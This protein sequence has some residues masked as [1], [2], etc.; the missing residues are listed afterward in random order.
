MAAPKENIAR[1]ILR[2]KCAKIG[3]IEE[4]EVLV[5]LLESFLR[6]SRGFYSISAPQ[7]NVMKEVAIVRLPHFSID[8]INPVVVRRSHDKMLSCSE[9]C[10]SFPAENIN[11]VR[12][13]E[14]EIKTGFS[15]QSV[16]LNGIEAIF[17]QHEIDHLNGMLLKDRA[18]K[19]AVVRDEGW[20]KSGDYCPCGSKKRFF[21]CC[22][23]T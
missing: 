18:I 14:V 8:L 9:R 19:M 20:L 1:E 6:E 21:Q 23:M 11:C 5:K 17:V 15:D 22:K 7:I 13:K 10:V 12:S 16:V 4:G 2:K 3:G